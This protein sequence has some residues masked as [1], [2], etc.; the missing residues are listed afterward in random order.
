MIRKPLIAGVWAFAAILAGAAAAPGQTTYT[1]NGGGADANWSTAANW[2][3][4]GPGTPPPASDLTNTL[5]I[6]TGAT[7]LTN[8]L[9]YNLSANSLTF[10]A[11]AGAFTV[12]GTNTLTLGT[13]GITVAS[14]NNQT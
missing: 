11:A 5:I 2:T 6:L 14:N 1:W 4:T 12:N 9:D 7:R 8:T 13:G 10:D 3:A